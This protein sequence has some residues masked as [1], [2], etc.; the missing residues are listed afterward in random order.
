MVEYTTKREKKKNSNL[1]IHDKVFDHFAE[2]KNGRIARIQLITGN[3]N[4]RGEF[5]EETG[6]GGWH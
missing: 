3:S 2:L 5:M 6:E 1:M 4:G